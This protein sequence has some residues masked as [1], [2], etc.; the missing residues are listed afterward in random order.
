MA[1]PIVCVRLGMV[2]MWAVPV[3]VHML[4]LGVNVTMIC[5]QRQ[6]ALHRRTVATG[7]ARRHV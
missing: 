7:D 4:V 1:V 5:R 2:P 6:A 3:V